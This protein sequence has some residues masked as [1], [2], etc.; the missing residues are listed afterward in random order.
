MC[1]DDMR[2]RRERRRQIR[3]PHHCTP[4]R[5]N[6]PRRAAPA[7]YTLSQRVLHSDLCV[8]KELAER[9]VDGLEMRDRDLLNLRLH[10]FGDARRFVENIFGVVQRT[11]GRIS[12]KL[13][14][15]RLART[16]VIGR[17]R[18]SLRPHRADVA[19]K[20][21]HRIARAPAV[22]GRIVAC[23]RHRACFEVVRVANIID[24]VL[25]PALLP[26]SDCGLRTREGLGALRLLRFRGLLTRR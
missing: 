23:A 8:R 18:E 15:G 25:R 22:V 24:A 11:I 9:H 10:F 26:V 14:D 17:R 4:D 7:T 19:D 5:P 12:D 2:R 20:L 16:A 3:T 1:D 13:R 21:S 6:P